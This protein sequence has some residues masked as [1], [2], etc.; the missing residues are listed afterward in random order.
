M[1]HS[2]VQ[3]L[4]AGAEGAERVKIR[5]NPLFQWIEGCKQARVVRR[6]HG[7][8]DF[9]TF[10]ACGQVRGRAG[11]GTLPRIPLAVASIAHFI[12][13]RYPRAIDWIL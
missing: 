7:R 3:P 11:F 9:G 6:E 8:E 2:V 13:P 12:Y 5:T 4:V 1:S 10:R